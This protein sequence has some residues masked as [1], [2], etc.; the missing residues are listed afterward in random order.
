[1][2]E[3]ISDR[4]ARQTGH[5]V[6]CW[7][8]AGRLLDGGNRPAGGLNVRLLLESADDLTPRRWSCSG[9]L[10]EKLLTAPLIAL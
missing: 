9:G 4:L 8:P 7:S 3:Q 1:M 10:P 2:R 6:T 5:D